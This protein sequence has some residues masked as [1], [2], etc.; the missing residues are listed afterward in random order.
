MKLKILSLLAFSLSSVSLCHAATLQIAPQNPQP[1]DVLSLTIYP[2]SG[3]K[4]SAV[5]MAAF[6]TAQVKFV[7]REDGS[8]RAFVGFPFDRS[9][10]SFRSRR[11]CKPIAASR[12]YAPPSPPKRAII[13]RSASR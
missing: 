13:P 12:F 3:E 8:A 1:G 11:G 9:G 4:I 6:D 10:G 7:A 5:G 2:A